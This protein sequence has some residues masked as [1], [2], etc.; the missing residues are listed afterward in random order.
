MDHRRKATSSI[1][2]FIVLLCSKANAQQV[3]VVNGDSLS[4]ARVN[5]ALQCDLP[6]VDCDPF[7]G[8]WFCASYRITSNTPP[9]LS[10]PNST[11]DTGNSS[12]S[13]NTSDISTSTPA[14]TTPV[15][16]T[17]TTTTPVNNAPATDTLRICASSSS[18]SD[19]DG[20]GWENNASC[21]TE[22]G[23]SS[24]GNSS[25][26][27]TNTS[28]STS[29]SD[30]SNN[31]TQR[32]ECS[33]AASDPDGDG[34][35]WENNA[36]CIVD[37]SD[38]RANAQFVNT[39]SSSTNTNSSGTNIAPRA[40]CVSADS[41]PDGDGFGWENNATCIVQQSSSSNT[42]SNNSS[43]NQTQRATDITD[44][45]LVTGQSNAL[46]AGTDY[47][48][49]LDAPNRRAFA[50]TNEGWQVANLRQVWDLRWHPR[51]HPE[52]DPSN[53]FAL[54]FGKKVAEQDSQRVVGFILI[55]APGA[56]ISHW[57]KGGDF[58]PQI[59]NKVLDAI[60]QLPQKSAID[61]ILWHQG[62]SDG[63]DEQYYTDALYG[64]I[65]DLRA[66]PWVASDAAFIC[67]ETKIRSVN[68]RLNGLNRDS[69]PNTACVRGEDLST[70]GDDRHFD[71][72]GL[73]TLGS[74]YADAWVRITN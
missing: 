29:S 72:A 62:E 7:D 24:S 55:T 3:C 15:T 40:A 11:T 63:R 69:D 60:N 31:S 50:F 70:R 22:A 10:I 46:G 17:P 65:S 34:F 19:G 37:T 5:Y 8:Q 14:M 52:T 54:H 20:F 27:N 61:G 39:Q 21:I 66:E 56:G 2:L 28:N 18:D 33:S 73:R 68:N 45:V 43:S 32:A 59:R 9:A 35:G 23:S 47:N 36:T 48:A 30:N 4:E 64:L 16:N 41:D 25:S 51:N 53:N 6:R 26:G 49:S 44:L 12:N 58:Y 1:L 57:D 42:T 74:R 71:A 38:G 67:G 13:S